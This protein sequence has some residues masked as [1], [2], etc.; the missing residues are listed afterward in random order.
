MFKITGKF[1]IDEY[2]ILVL[3]KLAEKVG[4]NEAIFLQQLHY[5]ISGKSAKKKDG[6]RW[7]YNTYKDW[8]EQ[9]PFWSNATIRRVINSCEKKN[10][11][12]TTSKYNKAGYDNTKWYSI[13]YNEVN[14]LSTS[15]PSENEG[16]AQSEQRD[17]SERASGVA[18]NEQ[19]N[20]RDYTETTTKTKEQNINSQELTPTHPLN[21][22]NRINK[23]IRNVGL[24]KVIQYYSETYKFLYG[25]EHPNYKESQIIDVANTLEELS[26]EIQTFGDWKELINEH[27]RSENVGDGRLSFFASG[28]AE[29]GVIAGILKKV[30]RNGRVRIQGIN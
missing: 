25:E 4:L 3:P 19:T 7:I 6:R 10:L 17:E 22:L 30:N 27:F 5:W 2:P 9:F 12:V 8:E 24:A 13:N 14:R 23:V 29:Q 28:D 15:L 26:D 16:L 20:T 11:I 1:L 18:Q 21:D